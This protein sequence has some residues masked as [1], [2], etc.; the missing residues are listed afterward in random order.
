MELMPIIKISLGIFIVLTSITASISY[1]IYKFKDR[2]RTKPYDNIKPYVE[3]KEVTVQAP[4]AIK[5][6][7][8]KVIN[9]KFRVVNEHKPV[10]LK[11]QPCHGLQKKM[12]PVEERNEVFIKPRKKNSENEVFNIYNLYS[13][14]NARPM[15]KL[16]LESQATES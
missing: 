13:N 11:V 5:L 1:I 14:N 8:E 9:K 16:K 6:P 7:Q 4:R 10:P 2:N 15:H 3:N 12:T